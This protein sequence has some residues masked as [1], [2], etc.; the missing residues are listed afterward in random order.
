MLASAS[1]LELVTAGAV[2]L[3]VLVYASLEGEKTRYPPGILVPDEPN[4][5]GAGR[6]SPW[7]Y[8][9]CKITPL[10]SIRMRARV[11][12]AERYWFDSGAG[13][14][15]VDLALGWG[16]MSD[17]RVIDQLSIWQGQRWY[18]WQPKGKVLPA[19]F[20]HISRYSANMHMIP[21]SGQVRKD[22]LNVHAGQIVELSGDLVEVEGENGWKWR[23]SLSRTDT[24]NGACE[25]VWLREISVR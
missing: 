11:L 25:L 22:L 21:S 17:Q 1:R 15:P 6:S 9:N 16:P 5:T 3:G 19:S 2:V 8:K 10:A 12:S 14:A 7:K 4:Q 24:G 18:H 23:S 13:L 20:A